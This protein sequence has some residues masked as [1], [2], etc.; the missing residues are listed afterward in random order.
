MKLYSIC[1]SLVG[2]KIILNGITKL[3]PDTLKTMYREST[4][5]DGTCGWYSL[6]HTN[7]ITTGYCDADT[8][9]EIFLV[10][11]AYR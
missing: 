5:Y 4:G 10:F 3:S 1:D 8:G 7:Y 6:K 2:E 9:H 11:D